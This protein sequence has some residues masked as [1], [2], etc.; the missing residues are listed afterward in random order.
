MLASGT[1]K[2]HL[3]L[4]EHVWIAALGTP[5]LTFEQYGAVLGAYHHFYLHVEQ[6]CSKHSF[7]QCLSLRPA[8]ERL[9]VD[10]DSLA[11]PHCSRP[12][13][14]VELNLAEPLEMLG[15]LY[16]LHGSSFGATLL[17][18]NVRRVLPDAPRCFLAAGTGRDRWQQLNQ[19]LERYC[20]DELA[21][22]KILLGANAT[23]EA[24]GRFVTCHC[25]SRLPAQRLA[26]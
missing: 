9:A 15:A 21:R 18:R 7:P 25:E 14:P 10:I 24:F 12:A 6:A 20:N 11:L 16:V 22:E 4:H 2:V 19:E 5:E 13:P 17:N 23:F 8:R 3:E 26:R 1:R